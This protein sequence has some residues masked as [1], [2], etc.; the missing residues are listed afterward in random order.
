VETYI[1]NKN[2]G[3]KQNN[4]PHGWARFSAKEKDGIN[5]PSFFMVE[6]SQVGCFLTAQ[7]SCRY[8]LSLSN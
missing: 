6:P 1:K 8:L 4:V 2:S 3:L 5:I 7:D